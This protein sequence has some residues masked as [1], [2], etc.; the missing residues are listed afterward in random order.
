MNLQNQSHLWTAAKAQRNQEGSV[1]DRKGH[2][3]E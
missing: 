2:K 3:S 1:P